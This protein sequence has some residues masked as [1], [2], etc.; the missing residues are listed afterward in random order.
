MITRKTYWF[1]KFNWFITSE[2]YLIISGKD[3]QQNQMLVKK[4]MEKGDIYM[5]A[6]IYGAATVI[7]KNPS[8]KPI[9]TS[10]LEEGAVFT[11]CRSKAWESKVKTLLYCILFYKKIRSLQV[12]GGFMITKFRER[13]QQE[14]IYQLVVL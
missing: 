7:V 3:A 11:I 4:Y 9:P 8:K 6:D 5:H 12:L 14:N 10:S 13:H 1:E 2:N